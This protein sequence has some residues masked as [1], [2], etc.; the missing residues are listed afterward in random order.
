MKPATEQSPVALPGIQSAY[1]G[2][3]NSASATAT[4]GGGSGTRNTT[5]P[6][7]PTDGQTADPDRQFGGADIQLGAC[8][9]DCRV[10]VAVHRRQ[11]RPW[12][13]LRP[14]RQS[15][16]TAP[17]MDAGDGGAVVHDPHGGNLH[18]PVR[19]R[20]GFRRRRVA[21]GRRRR[22]SWGLPQPRTRSRRG[23][24]TTSTTAPVRRPGRPS[25]RGRRRRRMCGRSSTPARTL[26]LPQ[27]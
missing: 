26:G 19:V 20:C 14:P 25:I 8:V 17:P 7:S 12:W 13:R 6:G 9:G 5:L 23:C 18:C 4:G 3:A 11:P 10:G 15:R 16:P 21:S 2:P 24:R 22:S 27:L 1:L